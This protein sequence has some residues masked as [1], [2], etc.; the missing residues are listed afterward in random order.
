MFQKQVTHKSKSVDIVAKKGEN[1]QKKLINLAKKTG[2]FILAI[3]AKVGQ[4]RPW[5][6]EERRWL[7]VEA[8]STNNTGAVE[9]TI[10]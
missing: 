1:C 10:Y 7:E 9:L 6:G 3:P 8:T 4:C 2:V 5:V